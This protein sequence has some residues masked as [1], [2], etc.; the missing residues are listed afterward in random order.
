M[1]RL[2]PTVIG[3]GECLWVKKIYLL[4]FLRK[5]N[6]FRS[7]FTNKNV[8]LWA[9]KDFPLNLSRFVLILPDWNVAFLE[10]K[11]YKNGFVSGKRM[12]V[13]KLPPF[14][15]C[16]VGEGKRAAISKQTCFFTE[17]SPFWY[18]LSSKRLWNYLTIGRCTPSLSNGLQVWR[19][20]RLFKT[21]CTFSSCLAACLTA[22]LGWQDFSKSQKYYAL[23]NY[24]NSLAPKD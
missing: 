8:L 23:P 15:P 18:C 14:F 22:I 19:V 21:Q 5:T 24:F 7:Q 3:S 13:L 11:Q 2:K 9:Y 6:C 4:H 10:L 17:A 12:L 16:R 1:Y 20:T